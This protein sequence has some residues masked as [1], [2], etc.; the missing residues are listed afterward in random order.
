MGTPRTFT[1]IVNPTPVGTN[2]T[3]VTCSGSPLN[4][5]LQPLVSNGV[6]STFGWVAANNT[7]I[8]G[9][10]TALVPS[11][12]ITNTLTNLTANALNVSYTVFPTNVNGCSGASFTVTVVVNPEPKV[13]SIANQVQTLCSGEQTL[14]IGFINT[15]S[16]VVWEKS[17]TNVLLGPIRGTN[18]VTPFYVLNTGLSP[19]TNYITVTPRFYNILFGVYCYGET[20]AATIITYPGASITNAS[21]QTQTKQLAASSVLSTDV[22]LNGDFT[23]MSYAFDKATMATNAPTGTVSG[24]SGMYNS[25]QIR[26][27]NTGILTITYTASSVGGVTSCPSATTN[28]VIVVTDTNNSA[29][30]LEIQ[31]LNLTSVVMQW[32]SPSNTTLLSATNLSPAIWTTN[33]VHGAGLN[34]YTNSILLPPPYRFFR[35]TNAP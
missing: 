6:A 18:E 20:N 16:D 17:N 23:T 1:V 14:Q 33:T 11:G 5:A 27:T 22:M 19:V 35:L 8:T 31:K 24:L 26:L 7:N 34:R 3:V 28:V 10:S 4:I 30:P 32:Y 29:L 15:P 13:T 9:E 25:G 12:T 21:P 2:L